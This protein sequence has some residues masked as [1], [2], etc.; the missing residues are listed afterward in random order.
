MTSR[1]LSDADKRTI[2]HL[3]EQP[4][5]TISSIA[6][7]YGVSK[8]IISSILKSSLSEREYE[9]LVKQKRLAHSDDI[10]AQRQKISYRV[11]HAIPGRIRFHVPQ[12]AID[13]EYAHK[14]KVVTE[15]DA[16]TTDI[17]VNAAASSIVITYELGVIS[18]DQMRSHLVKLIQTAPDTVVPN[19]YITSSGF[20]WGQKRFEMSPWNELVIYRLHLGAFD[21][22]NQPGNCDRIIDKLDYFQE[23]GINAIEL[24][25]ILGTPS[26]TSQGYNRALDFHIESNNGLPEGFKKFVMAAHERGIVIILEVDYKHFL[27]GHN[28]RTSSWQ[29]NGWNDNAKNINFAV[30]TP[31]DSALSTDKVRNAIMPGLDS[32][33]VKRVIYSPNHN[34]VAKIKHKVRLPSQ[35]IDCDR[36]DSFLAKKRYTLGA[37][38][39]FTSP[40]IPIIFQGQ[41]F[42]ESKTS[43]DDVLLN[44][45]DL[46]VHNGSNELYRKLIR[47]R[48]NWYNSTRG[49]RGQNVNVYH[50]NKKDKVI[51]F[52]RWENGGQGDDVVVVLNMGYRS[53]DSYSIGFP[54]EG[55]WWVRFNSSWK[56]YRANF[57]RYPGYSDTTASWTDAGDP[58]R[59]PCRGSVSL[60]PYSALILCQ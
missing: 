1:K 8:V 14:L 5:E 33:G 51:A 9:T 16:R 22:G 26:K 25:P 49:L 15:F 43:K 52:H 30:V 10:A 37:V 44:W 21:D 28:S 23:L 56:N 57:G 54:R 18:D 2:L 60:R 4:G 17:R 42:L 36:L 46:F 48:R 20:N 50:V 7:Y 47:L 29:F 41:E 53:Y 39:L 55:V 31:I 32:K 6:D 11:A 13:Y 45:D 34:E 58:D 24:V 12:L 40:G 35:V 27:S 38:L 3:Y 59:M 19:A